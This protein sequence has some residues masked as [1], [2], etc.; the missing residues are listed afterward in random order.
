MAVVGLS[1]RQR[2]AVGNMVSFSFDL[3]DTAVQQRVN[4][5]KE[6]Y[7]GTVEW[8]VG[9][10]REYG[11]ILEFGRGPIEADDAEALQ[12]EI[13]GET[14]FAQSVSG[15]PPYPWFEPAVREFER[16]PR[17]F[18]FDNTDFNSLSEIESVEELVRTV[19]IGLENQMTDNVSA[20]S[21]TDR[22][23]GTHPEHPKRDTGTLAASIQAI[24][25]Q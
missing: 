12:F 22:S 5:L 18:I 3:D 6:D 2:Q 9:T 1:P 4:E 21:A 7:T 8:A 17:G 24:R 19:A 14:V 10:D 11:R 25:V 20:D 13:D 23:P 16:N 15:H